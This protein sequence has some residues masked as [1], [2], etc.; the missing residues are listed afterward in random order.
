[1]YGPYPFERL[2]HRAGTHGETGTG[3]CARTGA[4][5]TRSE[6]GASTES[7]SSASADD[8]TRATRLRRG[9]NV[10]CDR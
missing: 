10:L 1:M 3:A 8:G 5:T 4:G 7:K 6:T 2:R 9:A